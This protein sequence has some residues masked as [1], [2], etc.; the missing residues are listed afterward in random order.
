MLGDERLELADELRGA[1]ATEVGV[2]P[3]LDRGELLLL[4]PCPLERQVDVAE[5]RATPECE[6][7]AQQL[8]CLL[9]LGAPRGCDELLEAV[10]ASSSPLTTISGIARLD[11]A[12]AERLAELGNV[13]LQRGRRRRRRVVAP[14]LVDQALGR[15][16]AAGVQ[17]ED[18]EEGA[19]LPRPTS[20]VRPPL[21]TSMGPSTP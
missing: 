21:R 5:R 12:F 11:R 15:H 8:G 18:G 9:G 4:Q 10:Q 20:I 1:A 19:L 17:R 2:H 13:D 3:L 16:H 6:R 7:L 14:E